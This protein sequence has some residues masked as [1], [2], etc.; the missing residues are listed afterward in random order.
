MSMTVHEINNVVL[1]FSNP[2]WAGVGTVPST[3]IRNITALS[4]GYSSHITENITVLTSKYASTMNGIIQGLL[5]V[6]SISPGDPCELMSQKYLPAKVVRRENLPP[7]NYNL[8][9]IAPWI[10]EDCTQSFLASARVDP[11]RALIFYRP[12]NLTSDAVDP[13]SPRWD[14]EDHGRWKTENHFPIIAVSS[15]VGDEVMR[16]LSLYSGNLSQVPFGENI[17]S[18]YDADPNDFV[19]IWTQIRVSTSSNIPSIGVLVAI[20][21][22]VLIG[23]IGST[24]V[25][26]HLVQNRRRAALRHRVQR[27]EVNLEAMGITRM[28]VPL[29]HVQKFPL[30]TYHYEP[31]L[32][33]SPAPPTPPKSL[34][35]SRNWPSLGQADSVATS[36]LPTLENG[37]DG[38]FFIPDAATDYQ[39]TCTICLE[40][41]HNRVTV[42]R[43]LSCGHIFHPDCIDAFLTETSSLCPVCKAC[44]LPKGYCPRIT[45]DMVRRERAI[46]R[47]RDMIEVDD[48]EGSGGRTAFIGLTKRLRRNVPSQKKEFTNASSATELRSAQRLPAT[49]EV[50]AHPQPGK[51]NRRINQTAADGER[52]RELAEFSLDYEEAQLTKWQKLRHKIFPGF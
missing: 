1:L 23:V 13:D 48:M 28:T 49:G 21:L 9:A 30:F 12:L 37:L 44:I 19:R 6:P 17:S 36:T 41:Y 5:Y 42:I 31:E 52:M 4:L 7:T 10:D 43:E 22:C 34:Q 18:V 46:R 25:L 40:P 11:L 45:N 47:L 51:Y 24:S 35:R 2:V 38:P 33:G 20:I 27:G 8:I 29:S 15:A 14:L 3:I 32:S 50:T 16:Q 26:M 39:P